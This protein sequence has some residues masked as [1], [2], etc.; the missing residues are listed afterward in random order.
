MSLSAKVVT[1]VFQLNLR[2]NVSNI[3][4]RTCSVILQQPRHYSDTIFRP[5]LFNTKQYFYRN[6]STNIAAAE[7]K[8]RAM[9]ALSPLDPSS[10]SR[11]EQAIIRHISLNLNVDFEKHVLHGHAKLDVDVLEDINS[12]ILD[13]SNLK[14]SSIE[15]DDGSKL[16]YKLGE[17]I[18]NMGSKLTI[19][20]PK[21][22]IAGEKL[23][24]KIT[25]T[26]DPQ[27]SALQWLDPE[28][29]SGKKHPY[30][31]SQCQPIHAR[32]ILPCQ[33]TPAVKFT[34]DAEVTAPEEFT[35]L[36]SALRGEARSNRTTFRQP[37]P[38]P[39]YLVAIAVG[40]LESRTLGPRS[41]V[42]SEKEEIERSAWEF[43]E[44]E[45]YLQAA[46][47]LCGPY[48]WSEYDLLVLPPSFPYGGMENPCLTFVT[49]TLLAGDRSQ[50]DVIVHE[51]MHSWTG[52]LVTNRNFEHFWLNEGF[53]VFLERK[54]GASLINDSVEA[55]RSRDFQSLLGLQE[56]SE[57]VSVFGASSPLTNLVVDLNGIHPD[58]AFSRVPYE[59]GSLFLRYLEDQ[60]GGPEV[61]DDF[62]RAY[63]TKFRKKSLDTE[64]FKAFLLEYFKDNQAIKQ[65]DWDSWLH[66]S[67]MPPIIPDYDT[68]MTK[69]ISAL[70]VKIDDSN[71]SLSYEDVANFTPHQMIH[72]L[73]QLIDR[74]ALPLERL[75]ALG[76][77]YKVNGNKNTEI[78][79][80]WLRLCIRSR[81]DTKLQDVFHFV[82]SQGR[83]KYVRPVYRD[84]Y[85]WE[86]VR[87]RAIDNFLKNEKY[88]MHVSAYTLRKD[89]HLDEKTKNTE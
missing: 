73:Q 9:G 28:Q 13:A 46:E 70:L 56:L 83:M 5:K 4:Q 41:R 60:V 37:M 10:F 68:T 58:D 45:K 40:V 69:A 35:V 17:H 52:N 25:Y 26:T 29:T 79:Y 62:L 21:Q 11:P 80:R 81:D 47:K 72:M 36:M 33:D 59:K 27:A 39:S 6:M 64:Q 50:A 78:L 51:I 2:N 49:P 38:L 88:M 22:H 16:Q 12:L 71:A 3:R 55:K 7:R 20:L 18:P 48:E 31:F 57:A 14:I 76:K 66:K 82:N 43:A 24:I 87:A 34:Y 44:T 84:L 67:G 85:A 53:T 23:K 8:I 65:V 15:A 75:A 32:S 1:R 42:W 74:P 77:E 30:L 89:L 63:L 19:L 54:V 61:F 86:D